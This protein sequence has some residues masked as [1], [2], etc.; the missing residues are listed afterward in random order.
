M[1]PIHLFRAIT[2]LYKSVELPESSTDQKK[3]KSPPSSIFLTTKESSLMVKTSQ[4]KSSPSED[5]NSPNKSLESKEEP[6]A[7]KSKPSSKKKKLLKIMLIAQ[8]ESLTPDKLED[9]LSLILKDSKFWSWEEN[10]LNSPVPNPRRKLPRRNDSSYYL[11]PNI[12]W[13]FSFIIEWTLFN[14]CKDWRMYKL[15]ATDHPIGAL[16]FSFLKASTCSMYLM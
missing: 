11:N 12:F 3:V 5:S 14:K 9:S 8:S 2:D 1:V 6:K 7:A 4:D 16:L 15:I 13:I 10:S